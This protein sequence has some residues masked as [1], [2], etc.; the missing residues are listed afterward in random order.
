MVCKDC[1]EEYRK[2]Y[3][4]DWN[5]KNRDRL[6]RKW[7]EWRENNKERIKENNRLWRINN[8]ERKKAMD[9]TYYNK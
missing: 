3:K 8:R 1:V 9:N 2:N 5:L 7:K 6:I 4:K